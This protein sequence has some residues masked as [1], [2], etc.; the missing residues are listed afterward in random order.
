[1][2]TMLQE[3]AVAKANYHVDNYRFRECALFDEKIDDVVQIC[4]EELLRRMIVFKPDSG[5]R[6]SEYTYK[7][8]RECYM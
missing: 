3:L 8:R 6:I 1:M 4:T 2:N 7:I 5:E